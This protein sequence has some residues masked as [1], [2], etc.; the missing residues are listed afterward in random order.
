M[1]FFPCKFWHLSLQGFIF[2][3]LI[4]GFR[5]IKGLLLLLFV[6]VVA[7]YLWNLQL[8]TLI[9]LCSQGM[10]FLWERAQGYRSLPRTSCFSSYKIVGFLL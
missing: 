8:V 9:L 4:Q 7:F 3:G 10:A 2:Y 1:V 6:V 5:V